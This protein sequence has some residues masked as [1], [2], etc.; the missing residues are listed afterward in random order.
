MFEKSVLNLLCWQTLARISQIILHAYICAAQIKGERGSCPSPCMQF[1][2]M[3][4]APAH[5][6]AF[7][8]FDEVRVSSRLWQAS[9]Y[10]FANQFLVGPL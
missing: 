2:F 1:L 6:Q 5:I 9:G 10:T 3:K 8:V 4:E 7:E